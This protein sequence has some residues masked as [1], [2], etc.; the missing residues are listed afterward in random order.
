MGQKE[1]LY[2]ILT[3]GIDFY[4]LIMYWVLLQKIFQLNQITLQRWNLDW[5][6]SEQ[7][8]VIFAR[9]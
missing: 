3:K 5:L 4:C 6:L 8:L 1:E 2:M 7:Y 9:M